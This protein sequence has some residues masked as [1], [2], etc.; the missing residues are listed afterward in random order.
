MCFGHNDR[1][2]AWK[3]QDDTLHA[4]NNATIRKSGG[5]HIML[6]EPFFAKERGSLVKVNII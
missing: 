2:F 1:I 6:S 5:E 3:C 4:K